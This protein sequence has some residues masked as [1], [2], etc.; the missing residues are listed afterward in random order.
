[1][2]AAN[3]LARIVE[4]PAL[5]AV[6]LDVDGTLAAIVERPGDARV[7]DETRA[8]LRRL[9]RRYALVACVSGRMGADAARV[10]GVD[11]I[12]YV[13]EHGLE[14]EPE[15]ESWSD[16]VHAFA[17]SVGWPD[18]EPKRLTTSLHYRSATD[19]GAAEAEL[20][21]VAEQALAAGLRPHWG[22]MV[23]EIRPPVDADKGTA[24]RRLLERHGLRRALYAGDDRTDLD[25][26]HGL[27]GVEHAVRIAVASPEGPEE[28]GLASDLVVGSTAALLELLRQL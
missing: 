6:F 17:A 2:A 25:G 20:V 12:T 4:D 13:G 14:L 24:V 11:G 3:L 27:D 7:P 23:L 21:R 16:R 15:A 18:E 19:P 9:V 8:E 10:V 26:F 28:L 1:M 22:R 5:A